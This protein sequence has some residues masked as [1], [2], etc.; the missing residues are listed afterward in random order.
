M[1]KWVG[2]QT[3]V[4]IKLVVNI[5]EVMIMWVVNWTEVMIKSVVNLTEVMMIVAFVFSV[6]ATRQ[7]KQK[8]IHFYSNREITKP[9]FNLY[10]SY[11]I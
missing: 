9:F 7:W 10:S 1:F 4:M 11:D 8:G 2:N 6:F 3:K 5:I